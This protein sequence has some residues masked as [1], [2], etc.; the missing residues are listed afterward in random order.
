MGEDTIWVFRGLNAITI[1]Q[2]Y[3]SDSVYIAQNYSIK[4]Q[5]FLYTK[6]EKANIE[7]LL[8]S[9]ATENLIHPS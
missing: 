8:N 7:A 2:A 6:E 5:V 3:A 1:I 9:G 4:A